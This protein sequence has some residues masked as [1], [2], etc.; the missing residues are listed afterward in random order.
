MPKRVLEWTKRRGSSDRL[1]PAALVWCV[2]KPGRDLRE[3]VET[4]LAWR[5]VKRDVDEGILGGDFDRS[6]R[7]ELHTR[8]RDAEE[9]AKAEVWASYRCVALADPGEASGLK[10][11]D[12]G[13]GHAS[14]SETLAGRI[15]SALK[16]Y[17]LL[18]ESVGAGC[19]E[20]NW[21][22]AFKGNQCLAA[23]EPPPEFSDRG[24]DPSRGSRTGLEEQDL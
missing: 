23:G 17:S 16:S 21:P 19:I 3:K 18:N 22:P 9:S 13:A 12:L 1:Y 14:A 4:W 2:K 20:R 7:L 11:I 5:R 10:I 24:A 15:I 8:V 6:D